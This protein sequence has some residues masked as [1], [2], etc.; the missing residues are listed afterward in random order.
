[1][2]IRYDVFTLFM[3][4]T[5][6]LV[7]EVPSSLVRFTMPFEIHIHFSTLDSDYDRTTSTLCHSNC[8]TSWTFY[9]H[10]HIYTNA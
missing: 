7:A 4:H 3:L 10:A 9:N 6:V 1:M 2:L 5:P 8:K